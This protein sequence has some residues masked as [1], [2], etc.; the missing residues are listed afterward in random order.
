MDKEAGDPAQ[1]TLTRLGE[2]DEV[3]GSEPPRNG[4]WGDCWC[5]LPP[6]HPEK[7]CVCGPCRDRYG[8]PGWRADISVGECPE[9]GGKL[10][11]GGMAWVPHTEGYHA[12]RRRILLRIIRR[13]LWEE[14]VFRRDAVELAFVRDCVLVLWRVILP[15]SVV[16]YRTEMPEEIWDA[17]VDR[18]Q[19]LATLGRSVR[20][21]IERVHYIRPH[22]MMVKYRVFDG[23]SHGIEDASRSTS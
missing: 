7:E 23:R 10:L 1:Q 4:A 22:P 11:W 8:A 19:L 3:C 5:T 21:S 6:E 12:A 9:C 20:D 16:Y 14:L 18:E 13:G 2:Q 15:G 17:D